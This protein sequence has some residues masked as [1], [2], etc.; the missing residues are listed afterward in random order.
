MKKI[1]IS[2]VLLIAVLLITADVFAWSGRRGPT[3]IKNPSRAATINS[4]DAAQYNPAGLTSLEAGMYVYAGNQMGFKTKKGNRW[5]PQTVKNV[6][7]L[8]ESCPM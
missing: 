8:Q 1:L 2:G 7:S 4:I 5:F 3:W 6:I